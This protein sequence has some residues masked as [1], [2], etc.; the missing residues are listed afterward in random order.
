MTSGELTTS[1][2]EAN[3]RNMSLRE[4]SFETAK[5]AAIVE[6]SDS[7]EFFK[8][9]QAFLVDATA[10]KVDGYVLFKEYLD[11]EI[12][13][14]KAKKEALIEMCDRVIVAKE[15]QL[16]SLKQTLIALNE[17]GLVADYLMG[18][19]KA[20][21]IR[22]NNKPS[23]NLLGR[24]DDPLLP[25][26][27]KIQETKWVANREAIATAHQSGEDVSGWATVTWGKQV[28]FKN[29]PRHRR[30]RK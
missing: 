24:A 28:R 7:D 16:K 15:L 27:F 17:Q 1:E 8:E 2:E 19:N 11:A 4:L 18:K 21:E 13:Q 26:H 23:I 20:I 22:P 6:D 5:L 29:A 30:S 3:F 14:W 25:A 10:D 12:E 9:L